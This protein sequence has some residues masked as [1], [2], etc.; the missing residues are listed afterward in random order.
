MRIRVEKAAAQNRHPKGLCERGE[1]PASEDLPLGPR[2]VDAALAHRLDSTRQRLA[3]EVIHHE[4]A[5]GDEA[6]DGPGRDERR[7][8]RRA[9]G[10]EA[11]RVADALHRRRLFHKVKLL[12]QL[13]L[14][15]GE[16]EIVVNRNHI[17]SSHAFC[18]R[19]NRR[20]VT[21]EL[22]FDRRSLHLD[23]HLA[24]TI[25]FSQHCTVYL[26]NRR[27]AKRLVVKFG[28]D[29]AEGLAVVQELLRNDRLDKRD[30][31]WIE[32]VSQP[33]EPLCIL[34]GEEVLS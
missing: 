11:Q 30:G 25:G 12:G 14:D 29:V 4:D 18:E 31:H 6:R 27:R 19:L 26:R 22:R 33:G 3:L 15:L 32:Q 20:D 7:R 23:G 16:D 2:G 21:H 28:E 9:V 34:L 1:E 17:Y 10:V 5:L 8:A 13:R 24:S